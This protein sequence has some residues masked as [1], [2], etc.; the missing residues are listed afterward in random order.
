MKNRLNRIKHKV[1]KN[2]YKKRVKEIALHLDIP[3]C[4]YDLE[5]NDNSNSYNINN[6]IY[7]YPYND[8]RIN[9]IIKFYK[10]NELIIDNNTNYQEITNL[11]EIL[12]QLVEIYNQALDNKIEIDPY[13]FMLELEDEIM[14]NYFG[15]AKLFITEKAI[16]NNND[17]KYF[18]NVFLD[19]FM[20]WNFG[21][22]INRNKE[23]K[24][25]IEELN[26]KA[27][28]LGIREEVGP[29]YEVFGD[30]FEEFSG[31]QHYYLPIKIITKDNCYESVFKTE[32]VINKIH[33]IQILLLNERGIELSYDDVLKFLDYAMNI[34]EFQ[35]WTLEQ[36][37]TN[38]LELTH[39]ELLKTFLD[40]TSYDDIL[41]LYDIINNMGDNNI[42]KLSKNIEKDF[43]IKNKK[44]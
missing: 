32:K 26:N 1:L 29:H 30:Q 43:K 7:F 14:T 36:K 3:L 41:S 25:K 33:D 11:D 12:I 42:K 24:E 44:R 13:S 18:I 37:Y 20:G 21:V 6:K 15:K 22:S 4:S 31:I 19:H 40:N 17:Y 2:E 35:L 38:K 8:G 23:L 27:I 5:K 16:S 28:D 10:D 39:D 9:K 34:D